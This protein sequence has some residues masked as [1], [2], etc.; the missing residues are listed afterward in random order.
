M[1]LVNQIDRKRPRGRPRQR[2]LDV[3]RKDLEK[4]KPD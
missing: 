4:L 3:V 2:W 1:V